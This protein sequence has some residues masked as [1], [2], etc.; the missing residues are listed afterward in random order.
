MSWSFNNPKSGTANSHVIILEG[1]ESFR[2]WDQQ[3]ANKCETSYGAIGR[4]IADNSTNPIVLKHKHPGNKPSELEERINPFTGKHE[5]DTLKYTRADPPALPPAP[6]HSSDEASLSDNDSL[7]DAAEVAVIAAKERIFAMPLLPD[8]HKQ[9]NADMNAYNS[10]LEKHDGEKANL[11]TLDDICYKDLLATISLPCQSTIK[12]NPKYETLRKRPEDYYYRSRDYIALV[13]NTFSTGSVRLITAN[14]IK[15]MNTPQGDAKTLPEHLQEFQH[16]WAATAASLE[17]PK[18]PGFVPLSVLKFAFLNNSLDRTTPSNYQAINNYYQKFDDQMLPD[19]LISEL[20]KTSVGFLAD[21]PDPTSQQGCA[22]LAAVAPK[23]T[24]LKLAYGAKDP[25]KR[26]QHCSNC[27]TLTKDT[28]KTVNGVIYKGP[29]YFYHSLSKCNRSK[30]DA[31]NNAKAHLAVGP[32]PV[33]APAPPALPQD[34]AISAHIDAYFARLYLQQNA[35]A[36]STISNATH[37]QP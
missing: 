4:N 25:T 19:V 9:F 32:P 36:L 6:D 8:S 37:Q 20:L 10:G 1:S 28:E 3:T 5:K 21:K 17:D 24:A 26:N 2:Q 14:I 15:C 27:L 11:R 16:L 18:N 33:A 22:L 23:T 34:P 12:T 31:A 35:D 30:N 29:F 7:L 13:R